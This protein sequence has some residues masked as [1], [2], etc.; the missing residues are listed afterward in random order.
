MSKQHTIGVPYAKAS[1]DS[2][3][4]HVTCPNCGYKFYGKGRTEDKVTKG[5]GLEYAIH[6]EKAHPGA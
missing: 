1:V 6:S 4:Y 5:A 2:H 3:G